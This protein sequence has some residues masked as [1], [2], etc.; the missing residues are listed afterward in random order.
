MLTEPDPLRPEVEALLTQAMFPDPGRIRR[1]LE[2]YHPDP[3]R[4]VFVWL[5]EGRPV[6][7]A[8]VRRHGEEVEA[9]HLGTAPGEERRGHARSLLHAVA[10]PLEA[11]RIVA[12]IHEGAAEF[13]RRARVSLTPAPTRGG[14]P[15]FLAVLTRP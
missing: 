15:R 1:K 5:M 7:A 12:E 6:N 10:T 2:R 3:E 4:R 13:H 14:S 8:G 11:Q 9:L